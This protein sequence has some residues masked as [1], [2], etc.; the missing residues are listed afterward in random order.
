M[1]FLIISNLN[2]CLQLCKNIQ[3]YIQEN[4]VDGGDDNSLQHPMFTT[5]YYNNSTYLTHSIINETSITN[6]NERSSLPYIIG[7]IVAFLVV[8][9]GIVLIVNR[10]VCSRHRFYHQCTSSHVVLLIHCT[11]VA[12]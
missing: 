3:E 7:V 10:E 11:S 4:V 5:A 1:L 12:A 2:K 6:S 9:I 8:L